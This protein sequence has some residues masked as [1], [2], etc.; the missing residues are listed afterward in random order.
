MVLT[1]FK[2]QS[3]SKY[4]QTI[5]LRDT[6][7]GI[8]ALG[9]LLLLAVSA[10]FY[11]FL[12]LDQTYV[13]SYSILAFLSAHMYFSAKNINDLQALYLFGM[14]ILLIKGLVLVLVAYQMGIINLFLFGSVVL[15]L[16]LM[17]ISAVD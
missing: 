4:A 10:L 7:V 17:P 8:R 3:L 16:L 13:Y 2:D 11:S 14:T 1:H 6:R 9:L 12:A 5:V 15:F